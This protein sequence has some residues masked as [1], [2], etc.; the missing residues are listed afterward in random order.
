VG[1]LI[2][3][4]MAEDNPYLRSLVIV[5]NIIGFVYNIPQVILTVRTKS[6]NDLSGIF[7]I[8]RLLSAVLWIIYTTILWSPDVFISWIITGTSSGILFYYKVRYS[9]KGIMDEVQLCD[10]KK[11]MVELKDKEEELNNVV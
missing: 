7:L 5:A 11:N 2:K 9:E 1:Y 3:K 6:A 8:M 4:S 10:K